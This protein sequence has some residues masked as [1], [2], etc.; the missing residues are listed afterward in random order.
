M[1]TSRTHLATTRNALIWLGLGSIAL[2][3]CGL[4]APGD[5]APTSVARK[6]DPPVGIAA[7]V[8]A[9]RFE[10]NHGQF[11]DS[12]RFLARGAGFGLSLASDGATLD[13][14]RGP[15]EHEVVGIRLAG[16]RPTEPVG[17]QLLEGRTNYF[18]GQDEQRWR[19]NVENFGRVS[20]PSALP[21]VD[22][23][24]YGNASGQL[25]YDVLLAPRVDVS[26]VELTFPGV[27]SISLDAR[28]DAVLRLPSG[29]VLLEKSPTAYQADARGRRNLV[30][31]RYRLLGAD[32]LGFAVGGHDK[33]RPLV[34]D[35]V[36]TYSIYLGAQNFD[37]L[38]AVAT[39][40]Q[41][42]TYAVGYTTGG[43]FPTVPSSNPLQPTFAGG[44]SDAVICKL[45][46]SGANFVYATYLGG[47]NADQAYA[48]AADAS[49]NAYVA[50]VTYSTNFP[51]KNPIQAT[52]AGAGTADGFVLKLNAAGSA[53]AYSTYL[54]GGSDDFP[55]GI[56][57]SASGN[58]RV[59][60]QTFS[61]AAPAFPSLSPFQASFGGGADAF[62][63]GFTSAGAIEFSSFLGG[64]NSEYATGVVL[65]Q[66]GEIFVTGWTKSFNFP[67]LNA[68]QSQ[69][70]GGV[71][72]TADAFLTQLNASGSSVLSSTYLGGSGADLATGIA[73]QSGS[74]I[75]VGSTSSTNFP[76]LNPAQATLGS[77]AFT[78]AFVTRFAAGATA[79]AYST[80]LGGAQD[81]AA[82][83]VAGDADNAY[84][85]GKTASTNF[86]LLEEF[87]GSGAI[88]SADA[89]MA[90]YKNNGAAAY[91]TY[92]GGNAVDFA[93]GIAVRSGHELH[94]VGNTFSP[95]FPAIAA[96]AGYT[97]LHGSQDGFIVRA[98]ASIISVAAVSAGGWLTLLL[99]GVV[100]VCV[101][102]FSRRFEPAVS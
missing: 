23:T 35:P 102:V 55:G 25:E 87:R 73:L 84:V 7:G 14:H 65:G 56:A 26:V 59:V 41:G 22:V 30:P 32:R 83:G 24:Y 1:A 50:G 48:V 43:L 52:L 3:L 8:A 53:L 81:D 90:A 58:A 16:A 13:L 47:S 85:V 74:P 51:L 86:P 100:L 75:V 36:L 19:T 12:V 88:G 27:S 34:I 69:I 72:G 77:P 38:F 78:D 61:N 28:G 17:S 63:T 33:S 39:D 64:N 62:V 11:A 45:D 101:A 5:A 82:A 94:V 92:L 10:P 68:F 97:G 96:P 99:L 44:G 57:V 54:G 49:G 15:D 42:N 2:A 20:Y 6:L 21:G 80:Y 70:G 89:F 67:T 29:G 93:T 91:S 37:Q 31:I 60:G 46:P 9:L 40:S 76:T 71:G 79:L 66:A 18:V 98:P 4:V 95:D